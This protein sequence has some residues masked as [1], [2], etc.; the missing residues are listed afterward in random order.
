MPSGVGASRRSRLSAS[1]C[2]CVEQQCRVPR[3]K[4]PGARDHRR[5][6]RRRK[7]PARR[8]R[9]PHRSGSGSYR[10]NRHAQE[11][12]EASSSKEETTAAGIGPTNRTPSGKARSKREPPTEWTD[13]LGAC[14]PRER[15]APAERLR[16]NVP[17][18]QRW[19][20]PPPEPTAGPPPLLSPGGSAVPWR[21]RRTRPAAR[22][23]PRER[24]AP[25]AQGAP[26]PAARS[27][28][29]AGHRRRRS[30]RWAA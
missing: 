14:P 1:D 12:R 26:G 19:K 21:P 15:A 27:A 24:D 29:S 22:S 20:E 16:R 3:T 25:A 6:D 9:H 11:P 30:A 4:M 13:G 7:G 8:M 28:S 2:C 17:R 10:R 23:G 5:N 18:R